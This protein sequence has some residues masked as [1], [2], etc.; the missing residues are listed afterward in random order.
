MQKISKTDVLGKDAFEKETLD[1]QAFRKG[2]VE[3]V[4]KSADIIH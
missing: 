2:I 4:L 3:M 1:Y